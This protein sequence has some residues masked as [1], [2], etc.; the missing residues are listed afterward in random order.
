MVGLP[1]PFM[2]SEPTLGVHSETILSV[3]QL[4]VQFGQVTA[5]SD[6]TFEVRRGEFLGVVG[7]SGAGKSATARAMLGLLPSRAK[8]T[9]EVI[10]DGRNLVGA[11][12]RQLR[13]VRG[14]RIS[15][16]FQDALTA[17]DPVYTIGHQL[18]EAYRTSWPRASK[19]EARARACQLLEEVQIS[20]PSA[21][22]DSYPHQLSGGMR[23]RVAI[24]I[25]LV[26]DPDI[27]VADEPTSA[28][29]VTVQR[30]ILELLRKVCSDRNAAVV[31]ITH[32]L[33]VVAE[34]C[35]RV[36]VL[37]G[38]VVAEEADVFSLFDSPQHPYTR[39]LLDTL[40]RRGA[41]SELR[42]IP[43]RATQVI[44]DLSSCPFANRCNHVTDEC[45]RELPP[46][47]QVGA[48]QVRC[49]NAPIQPG[50]PK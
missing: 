1:T 29:D 13:S 42:P 36:V 9:G 37:Y 45:T 34:T 49:T 43:G 39:A 50:V 20:S 4:R 32:D 28:L 6:V 12:P 46:T 21:R 10:H 17:L 35:D 7:E 11:S 8:V 27:V 3:D 31:L 24:A 18:M 38:G 15:Y 40:P 2:Q 30:R 44:G 41:D 23:Q 5:V 33:G 25:A 19:D 26:G 48:S 22:L 16:I 47:R 14:R